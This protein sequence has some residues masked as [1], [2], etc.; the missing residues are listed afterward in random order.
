VLRGERVPEERKIELKFLDIERKDIDGFK[1][2][3]LIKESSRD[4][5]FTNKT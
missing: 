4:V 3:I 2:I 5:F 1:Q